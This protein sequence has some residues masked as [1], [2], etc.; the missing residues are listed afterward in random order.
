M[1]AQPKTKA[2]CDELIA[3]SERAVANK[4]VAVAKYTAQFGASSQATKNA[5]VDLAEQKA[6]LV[7][8][9]TLRKTLK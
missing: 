3:I 4:K 5:K 1:G 7:R 2:Q 6:E 8:L 9:K